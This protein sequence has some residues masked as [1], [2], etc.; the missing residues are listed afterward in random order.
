MNILIV[1]EFVSDGREV[2]RLLNNLLVS[3][4]NFVVNWGQEGPSVSVSFQLIQHHSRK[5]TS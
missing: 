2:H 3:R 5:Y 4:H 1:G